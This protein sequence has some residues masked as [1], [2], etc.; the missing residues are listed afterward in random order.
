MLRAQYFVSGWLTSR[1]SV[2]GLGGGVLGGFALGI[3]SYF[4]PHYLFLP[5]Q[6]GL[7]T[8]VLDLAFGLRT[9]STF[10]FF[11]A[12]FPDSFLSALF[13]T[14]HL[15]AIDRLS[16]VDNSNWRKKQDCH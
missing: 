8:W 2:N 1:C 7:G 5:V 13:A 14:Q 16:L 11:A 6:L 9:F 4:R 15:R 12:V 3:G 10:M